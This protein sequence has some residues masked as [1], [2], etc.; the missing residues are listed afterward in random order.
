MLTAVGGVWSDHKC[1]VHIYILVVYMFNISACMMKPYNQHHIHS[2][3][4]RISQVLVQTNQ[5]FLL[6]SG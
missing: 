5:L 6:F 4:H 3:I 2:S 1:A